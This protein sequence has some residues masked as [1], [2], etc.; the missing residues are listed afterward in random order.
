MSLEQNF[1]V[2]TD[3]FDYS[4]EDTATITATGTEV[5]GAVEFQIQ[6]VSGPGADGVYGTADDVVIDLG[7]EGHESWIVVDGGAGDLDGLAN[8]IVVTEWYVNPD[9]SLGETFLLTAQEVD[10]GADGAFA[11]ADDVYGRLATNSFTDA[12]KYNLDQWANGSDTSHDPL[13]GEEWVNGNLGASKAHYFYADFVPYRAQLTDLEQ[14][15]TYALEIEFD[16]TEGGEYAIDYIGTYDYSFQTGAVHEGDGPIDPTDGLT[17]TQNPGTPN[18]LEI[19]L[20]PLVLAGDDGTIATSDDITQTPGVLTAWGVDLLGFAT[21]G[22]DGVIGTDDDMYYLAGSDGQWGTGDEVQITRGNYFS[23]GPAVIS[24]TI[25]SLDVGAAIYTHSGSV[26]SSSTTSFYVVFEYAGTEGDDG[27]IAWGGHIATPDDWANADPS[28]SPYHMRLLDWVG[29]DGTDDAKIVGTGNQD[30]S[31]SRNVIQDLD[32]LVEVDKTV[33]EDGTADP[34]VNEL[35]L[36]P[37]VYGVQYQYVITNSGDGALLDVDLVDDNGTPLDTSDDVDL[38]IDGVVQAGVTVTGGGFTDEDGDGILDDLGATG[39]ITVVW[40]TTVPVGDTE[41]VATVTGD[42]A[43]EDITY[44][45]TDAALVHVPAVPAIDVE[46]IYAITDA[47]PGDGEN[48][49]TTVD[50]VGD[51][52]TYTVTVENTGNV[53][54]TASDVSDAL[55][56]ADQVLAL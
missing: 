11:T 26:A 16:L 6:H 31:L 46:K 39:T 19:P 5:G 17:I 42:D 35:T 45:D 51:V 49:T 41:N 47:D 30:R 14:G 34:F 38:I 12:T 32:P 40:S 20:D 13:D 15:M 52:I 3:A 4:P 56:G 22:V 36:D 8:G 10:A 53:A 2:I 21:A 54:L 33:R 44:S 29:F 27:V 24:G 55:E 9:D 23:G 1:E 43:D 7:G 28:G 18:T 48:N 25:S 50:E 37:E